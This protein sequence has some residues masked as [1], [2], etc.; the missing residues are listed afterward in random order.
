MFYLWG[1]EAE[2]GDGIPAIGMAAIIGRARSTRTPVFDSTITS[3][4]FNPEW[5][6]PD[7][8]ARSEILPAIAA[9]PDYLAQHHMEMTETAGRRAF[10]SFPGRG[11]RSGRI[12]FVLPNVHGVYLHDTPATALFSRERRDFSHGCVRVADPVALAAW[13]LQGEDDWPADRIRAA[14][15]DGVTRTFR[16]EPPAAASSCSI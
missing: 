1:W 7:S 12:K 13:V 9:N 14:I 6:V 2:R 4:V 8:I 15:A 3:V 10:A 11:T 5:V 16:V